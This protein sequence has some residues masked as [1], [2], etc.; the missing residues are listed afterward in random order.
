M[1]FGKAGD[2]DEVRILSTNL[3]HDHPPD[4]HAVSVNEG[5]TTEM[6]VTVARYGYSAVPPG[7][8]LRL[9]VSGTAYGGHIHK[10]VI[11]LLWQ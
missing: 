3:E 11:F 9:S 6:K 2:G 1:N 7:Q 5:L 10:S 8:A 4:H